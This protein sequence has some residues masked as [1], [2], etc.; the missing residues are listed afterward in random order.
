M[1]EGAWTGCGCLFVI[2]MVVVLTIGA[3]NSGDDYYKKAS[4]DKPRH[5]KKIEITTDGFP[6]ACVGTQVDPVKVVNRMTE[7]SVRVCMG[8]GG[9][10]ES[11]HDAPERLQRGVT[12]RPGE[13]RE[14]RFPTA[15]WLS[16]DARR[17]YPLT[18]T[19]ELGSAFRRGDMVVRRQMSGDPSWFSGT[20]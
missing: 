7:V 6:V 5:V 4:C 8:R 2:A 15:G 19:S 9:R 13:S 14:L 18:L 3:V 20:S 17:N 1:S 16:V 10:C 12:L 11:G